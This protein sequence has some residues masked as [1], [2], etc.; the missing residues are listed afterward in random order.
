[1]RISASPSNC[2]WLLIVV[3][4]PF[5]FLVAAQQAAAQ[6][7]LAEDMFQ[8][9]LD[10]AK[11]YQLYADTS[12]DRTYKLN[13][14]P[15]FVWTNPRR[16]R[17]QVGHLFVWM[18]GDYPA[19]VGTIFSFPWQGKPENQRIVHE[20]HA[21]TEERI[22]PVNKVALKAWI[23][24]AGNR[25]YPFPDTPPVAP[26]NA[27]RQLQARQLARTFEAHTIDRE[28]KRWELRL[29][30]KE[31]MQY[32]GPDRV[33]ALFAMLGDAGA[34]PELLLLVEAQRNENQWQWRYSPV[35][36]TDQEIYLRIGTTEVWKSEHDEKNTR[37]HN[38]E[39]TYD[40]FQD[41]LHHLDLNDKDD[42]P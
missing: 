29:L 20:M 31:L 14:Q 23:P 5:C 19:V 32:E 24:T 41:T 25:F 27:R 15:L 11:A 16:A 28:G 13:E 34:D 40:R 26:G 38:A 36:M 21:L 12:H 2:F 6:S 35:R 33:G 4:T 37:F 10:A 18:D 9:H 8:V 22:F 7:V 1:M 17:G 30:G 3:A 39:S 42:G